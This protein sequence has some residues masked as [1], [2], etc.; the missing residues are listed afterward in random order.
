MLFEVDAFLFAG[1]SLILPIF[2]VNQ[3]DC[4]LKLHEKI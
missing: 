4:L 2:K 3:L 1:D